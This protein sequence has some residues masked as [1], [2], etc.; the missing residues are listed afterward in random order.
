MSDHVARNRALW[1]ETNRSYTDA[2]AERSWSAPEI[3]WGVFEIPEHSLNVLG[4]VRGL[5]AIELGCGTAYFSS[6]LAQRGA[7]PVGVDVTQA[8][9]E[10]ARR[11]QKQFGMQF[12]L[13]EASAESVPLPAASF[14]LAFS[15]Y[16]ASLWCEPAAW[17][18][19]A[20][21]LLRPGGR[22]IFLTTSVLVSM[23]VRDDE[24]SYAG[25]QLLRSQ[26][27][28]RRLQW[29]DGGVEFHP[30]HAEW[31]TLLRASGFEVERLE[32]LYA[33]Q[34][35]VDHEFYKLAKVDWA[36]RWPAEELWVARKR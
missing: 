20:A 12:P 3:S 22:L 36:Q 25:T 16:G 30:S 5:D 29:S 7:R 27:S 23:C 10:S 35:A 2:D 11:C 18:P 24:G 14:D 33:P 31:L 32:E 21:R 9:L 8:Q 34:G 13:L 17:I 19:E 4:D 6:W 15:E 28:V 26:P 1:T